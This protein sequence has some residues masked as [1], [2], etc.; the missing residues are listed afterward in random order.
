MTG[1]SDTQTSSAS[2][3]PAPAP[4]AAKGSAAPGAAAPTEAKPAS[5]EPAK[6][7]PEAAKTA[8]AQDPP[9]TA[10]ADK[11]KEAAKPTGAPE[12]YTDFKL[13]EGVTIDKEHLTGFT[14]LAKK[15]GL[16]QEH[17]QA[18]IDFEAGRVVAANEAA[19]KSWQGT[20][21]GWLSDAKA[22]KHIGGA[23]FEAN[24]EFGKQ[25][26]AK[27]GTKEFRAML[28]EVGVGNHPEMI[29]FTARVGRELG[30]D[31][32]LKGGPAGSDLSLAERIYGG[33]HK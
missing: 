26:I 24:V 4:E 19:V 5:A 27:F 15:I 12:K 3:A 10:E 1:T 29:R 30:D 8:L 20:V 11:T 22:D 23:N 9:K 28:D 18:L 32:I 2:A 6:A 31:A 25:A 17:A 7:A 21:S 14:D 13:P 16:S 33:T